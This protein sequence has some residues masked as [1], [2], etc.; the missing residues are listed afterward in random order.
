MAL[1]GPTENWYVRAADVNKGMY[2]LP[3]SWG[4]VEC[5]EEM[6]SRT[7]LS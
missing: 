2:I 5:V 7:N 4:A 6:K 3:E 1:Q